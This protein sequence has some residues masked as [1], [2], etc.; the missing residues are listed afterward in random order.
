MLNL[1]IFSITMKIQLS[2]EEEVD[3]GYPG[4]V[5]EGRVPAQFGSSLLKYSH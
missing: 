1:G 5:L 3:K 4:L 2:K